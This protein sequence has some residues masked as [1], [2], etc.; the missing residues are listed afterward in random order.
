L[1]EADEGVAAT[2]IE[3]EQAIQRA[4]LKAEKELAKARRELARR[5]EKV[6]RL[7]HELQGDEKDG[8]STA[9]STAEEAADIIEHLEEASPQQEGLLA[10]EPH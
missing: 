5:V 2:R 8:R 7:E 4:R 10:I 9:V 6:T 1:R 3:G